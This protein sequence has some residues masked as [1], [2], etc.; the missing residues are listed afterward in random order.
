MNLDLL[1]PYDI[2]SYPNIF[3]FTG[4]DRTGRQL[5]QFE[6][7]WRKNN[8]GL[9][10]EW[11]R[12]W[13][14]MDYTLVGFN[15]IGYDYPVIHGLTTGD[16][17]ANHE[18]LYA[19]SQRIISTPWEQRFSN[20]VPAWK[21]NIRQCD[22]FK[23]HHFDNDAKR[24]SLKQVE[25]VMRMNN[26]EDLPYEP[27]HPIPETDEAAG[28]LLDYNGHDVIAT[29]DFLESSMGAL[30]LRTKL[31]EKYGKDFTNHNDTKI[32][33]DIFTMGM[34]K[35]GV[36]CFTPDR[37]PRGTHRDQIN[38]G[39]VIF[40]YIQFER[41][42]FQEVIEF[43]RNSTIRETKGALNMSAVVDGFS[44]DFGLGGIHGSV[45]SQSHYSDDQYV[46][47][48]ADVASY[49]PNLAIKNRVYP[50]HLSTAFCDVYESLYEQRKQYS[51]KTHPHENKAL[52][53]ALNG[54]Y[55]KSNSVYSPFYDP[56]Y[57]MTIT[58]N[59][60]L[61]L[62]LLAEKLM[63]IPE[64]QMIQVNTDGLTVKYPRKYQ[65][66]Y[67]A[68]C[69]WWQQ[70]TCL[71]LEFVEYARMHIR[72]VNNYIAVPQDGSPKFKGAYV[73]AGAHEPKGELD[74]HQN[75]S[76]LV[77]K[78][79]AATA[80]LDGTPVR[81]FILNH[82]DPLDFMLLA[83]VG[84]K[85]SLVLQADIKWGDTVV[86]RNQTIQELQRITRYYISTDGHK[87]VKRMP[88][89]KRRGKTVDLTY[90]GWQ[91]K[92]LTGVNKNLKVETEHEYHR[93]LRTGYRTKDGGT[94]THGP[95]REIGI[96]RN[97]LVTPANRF[98][99]G[100]PDNI[101]YEYYITEAEKLV[102]GVYGLK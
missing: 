90:P 56:L 33:A 68:V 27:G 50:E 44:F 30:K 73:H 92:K 62:C 21:Q 16:T 75:H 63:Q 64:L 53:L 9:L 26:I 29:N 97:Y 28:L 78:K 47:M 35:A 96:D 85:D 32:G 14:N 6:S 38:L 66:H 36:E 39:Q 24:T 69:D 20:Q 76:A 15:N 87:L 52:K 54:V 81:E 8:L 48:D 46:V 60:Q 12:H 71:E 25:F 89:L 49:Y 86:F 94:W 95:T 18:A 67:D 77:V 23:I 31:G 82:T 10:V 93:A 102:N 43:L 100:M 17:P 41:P 13:A 42:E 1:I 72:D 7:S 19:V 91:S 58:V 5:I 2:E 99:G 74:W 57:T 83:K 4:Y 88:P 34:Q 22:L 11:L 45:E 59:G 55:G 79:A 37:K 101:N 51:K 40:P 65:Q 98:T 80:I 70:L 61:L 84:R 3:T